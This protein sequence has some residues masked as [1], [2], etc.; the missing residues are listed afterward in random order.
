MPQLPFSFLLISP[1]STSQ[2][3]IPIKCPCV[4][5]TAVFSKVACCKKKRE[6]KY[7]LHACMHP[8]DVTHKKSPSVF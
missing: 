6:E 8:Y 4:L 5:C 7:K 3:Y 1:Q 2:I